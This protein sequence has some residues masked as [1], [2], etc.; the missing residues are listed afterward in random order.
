MK[1]VIYYFKDNFFIGELI[2]CKKNYIMKKLFLIK[3]N[4]KKKII[5]YNNVRKLFQMVY[6][7]VKVC[8][9]VLYNLIVKEF[10]NILSVCIFFKI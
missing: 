2:F 5:E 8:I 1:Y 7:N 10:Y 6:Y 4:C 3:I 9:L